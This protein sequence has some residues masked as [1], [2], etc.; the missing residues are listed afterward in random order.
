VCLCG[1]GM[2]VC[3]GWMGRMG[4]KGGG[5]DQ[6]LVIGLTHCSVPMFVAAPTTSTFWRLRHV[7]HP[8]LLNQHIYKAAT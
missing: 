7:Q 5:T 2:R 4:G 1:G 8:I 3:M 6:C